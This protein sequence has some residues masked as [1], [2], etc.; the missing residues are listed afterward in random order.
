MGAC[1]P[2]LVWKDENREMEEGMEGRQG[3][4]AIR[5]RI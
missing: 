2:T 4:E 1:T 5:E 3:R